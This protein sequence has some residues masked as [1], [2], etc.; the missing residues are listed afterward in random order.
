MKR[1]DP[2]NEH[3]AYTS[4]CF[5]YFST[6][7]ES[8]ITLTRNALTLVC[9]LSLVAADLHQLFRAA[10]SAWCDLISYAMAT[11]F[12]MPNQRSNSAQCVCVCWLFV[13]CVSVA[14]GACC[15][16]MRVGQSNVIVMAASRRLRR[17]TESIFWPYATTTTTTS[18]RNW[19][20]AG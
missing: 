13:F 17:R 1:Y 3:S 6:I 18:I 7:G 12:R 8:A 9:F 2:T 15:S 4:I 10:V 11:N 5:P 19:F 16:N 20:R 14:F